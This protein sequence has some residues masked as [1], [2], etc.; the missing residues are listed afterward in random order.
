MF[1]VIADLYLAGMQQKPSTSS[2]TLQCFEF[3]DCG[4]CAVL[5]ANLRET[6]KEKVQSMA[7]RREAEEMMR[8]QV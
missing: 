1:P 8:A 7:S 5:K 3:L 2:S 4:E 6:E